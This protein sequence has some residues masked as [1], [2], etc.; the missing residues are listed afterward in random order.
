[1]SVNDDLG[2]TRKVFVV[3]GRNEAARSAIFTFLRAIGLDPI[4]WSKAVTMTGEGS[5]YPG[6]VLDAAFAAAQA[7]VVLLTPDDIA[8]L[9]PEYAK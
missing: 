9:R 1:V 5:P 6:Q 4:E 2:R 7:I 3:H 8:Y